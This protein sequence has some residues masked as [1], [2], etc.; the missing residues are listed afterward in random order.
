M[1]TR[2]VAGLDGGGSKTALCCMD[3]QGCVLL[4]ETF[5][6]LNI[7]GMDTRAIDQ[8]LAEITDSISKVGGGLPSCA[9]MTIAAAGTSNSDCRGILSAGLLAAGYQGYFDL[10]GDH[11]AA[12]QGAV[13]SVGA[14]LI[15]GT[16]SICFGRSAAGETARAG[17]WGYLLDDEGGGYAIGRDILKA[18]LRA[19]DKRAG[20][21]AL[22]AAVYER[23]HASRPEDLIQA[24]YSKESGKANIAGLAKLLQPAFLLGD[25]AAIRIMSRAA[26]ELLM[27]CEAV[28]EELALSSQRLSLMGGVLDHIP[29]LAD[30]V[31]MKLNEKYPLLRVIAP[32]HN[33]AWGAADL[34]RENYL[35]NLK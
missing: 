10:R 3:A 21:T 20:E 14:V 24:A 2:F 12:L 8:T 15:A 17:G 5:G 25:A 23:L 29:A 11:E 16:G 19:S 22:T 33:A 1:S 30:L 27:L 35:N 9:G 4:E 32:L 26:E 28:I 31:R 13:G 34:A 6:P 7:N 18:V